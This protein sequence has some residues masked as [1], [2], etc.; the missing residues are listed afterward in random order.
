MYTRLFPA[1]IANPFSQRAAP[2]CGKNGCKAQEEEQN[3]KTVSLE[4]GKIVGF[5]P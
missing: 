2:L 4:L 3:N 5:S 1:Q